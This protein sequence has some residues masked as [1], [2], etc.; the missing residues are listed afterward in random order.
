VTSSTERGKERISSSPEVDPRIGVEKI[1]RQPE[2]VNRGK[3][4][5]S[6]KKREKGTRR[7]IYSHQKGGRAEDELFG[8]ERTEG[9]CT[10][11]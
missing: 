2:K 6:N 5:S 10:S 9:D 8:E 11:S 1:E 7:G 3:A 4:G